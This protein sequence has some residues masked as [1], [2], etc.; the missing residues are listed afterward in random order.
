MMMMMMESETRERD[1]L[2]SLYREAEVYIWV[3]CDADKFRLVDT[4][5]V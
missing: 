2:T 1:S 4:G 5:G 3:T